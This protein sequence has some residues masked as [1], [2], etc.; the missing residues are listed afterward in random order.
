MPLIYYT[1]LLG[2]VRVGPTELGGVHG[3]RHVF[4]KTVCVPFPKTIVERMTVRVLSVQQW[5]RQEKPFSYHQT[6]CQ[7]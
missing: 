6:R 7:Q 2:Q 4:I 3:L 1:G 5:C